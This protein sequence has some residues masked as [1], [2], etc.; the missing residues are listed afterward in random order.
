MENGILILLYSDVYFPS[1]TNDFILDYFF[2]ENN[3][4]D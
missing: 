1:L 2:E 4:F 3:I